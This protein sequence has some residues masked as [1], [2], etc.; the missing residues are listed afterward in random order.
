[1]N[2]S[3]KQ[4]SQRRK[5]VSN[6]HMKKIFNLDKTQGNANEN[7]KIMCHTHQKFLSGNTTY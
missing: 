5:L 4:D 6:N 1:M 7:N 3:Y 2:K